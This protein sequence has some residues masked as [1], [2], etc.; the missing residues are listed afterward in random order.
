MRKLL[1]S[2]VLILAG[3]NATPRAVAAPEPDVAQAATIPW[4]HGLPVYDHVVIVVEENKDYDE[5][6][7]NPQAAY[8]NGV[9]KVEGASF[10]HMYGE[11]H[12]SQGNYFWMFSGSNQDVG[13]DDVLP[14]KW[15]RKDYP[16]VAGN[17]AAQLIQKGKTFKGYSETLPE[18]G[19]TIKYVYD[20]FEPI[21]GRKHV[22]WISFKNV[23]NGSTQAASCNLRWS[24][25]PIRTLDFDRLPTVSFVIPNLRNDMHNGQL[26]E[27]IHTGDTWLKKN[28]DAYYQWAKF[29]NSLLILTFDESDV[30]TSY[31]GLTNPVVE[32]TDPYHKDLQNHIVT[33]F[34]GARIKRGDYPESRGIT[35][36]NILRTLEAMYGLPKSGHQ[37]GN[38][39]GFGITDDYIITDVFTSNP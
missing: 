26:Q 15:N 19:S 31:M 8:I 37:Q 29:H 30:K 11:E 12:D 39:A 28:L 2:T 33:L 24:D 3:L 27:S 23:P 10:T 22:P 36:V 25:C 6:V 4:P 1:V 21:Y 14:A 35:H 18:I 32:P 16:L 9:L 17:L 13:F 7:G 20:G 34:A 38:A 5:I